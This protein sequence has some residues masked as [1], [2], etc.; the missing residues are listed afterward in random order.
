MTM[1]HG[2]IFL[3]AA[4]VALSLLASPMAHAEWGHRGG[5]W[6]GGGGGWGGHE[7][8]WGRGGY[9]HR[10]G[11]GAWVAGTLLGLGAAAVIGGVLASQPTYYAP[12]PV[13]YAPPQP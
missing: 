8:G 7:G 13:V 6:G 3:I 10:G 11:G 5:G 1:R 2:K 9:E 4:P 12:P